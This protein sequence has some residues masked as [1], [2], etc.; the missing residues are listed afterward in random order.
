MLRNEINIGQDQWIKLNL[1]KFNQ[2]ED[3]LYD[4]KTILNNLNNFLK[5]TSN[6]AV[7]SAA[8]NQE[9]TISINDILEKIENIFE[10]KCNGLHKI[11]EIYDTIV[12]NKYIVIK[13]K[14]E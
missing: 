9:S 4:I 11:D 1:N 5:T 10:E 12:L 7:A 8:N 13:Y 14:N 3:F 2:F 6:C